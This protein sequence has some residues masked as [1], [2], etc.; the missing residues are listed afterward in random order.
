MFTSLDVHESRPNFRQNLCNDKAF[1]MERS[2]KSTA[3]SRTVLIWGHTG[4]IG[5]KLFAKWPR[6]QW[7]VVAARSRLQDLAAVEAELCATKC[8][9]VVNAAA[10]TGRP[11]VDW[12][13]DHKATVLAVNY[14]APLALAIVCY[15]RNIHCT[16]LG[17]G[18]IYQYDDRH[19]NQ[20]S[21]GDVGFTDKDVPNFRG[22]FYSRTK[23]MLEEAIVAMQLPTLILRFRMPIAG[24]GSERC[25]LTKLRKYKDHVVGGLFNSVSYLPDL[26]PRVP[27]LVGFRTEGVLNFVQPEAVT[28]ETIVKLACPDET[29]HFVPASDLPSLVKAP[30]SNCVLSTVHLQILTTR[31]RQKRVMKAT[32]CLH[33]VAQKQKEQ[34]KLLEK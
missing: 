11:T 14:A 32:D 13:E 7:K 23:A 28:H 8:T 4:W 31:L 6:K 2:E 16:L 25:L 22:S 29:F 10:L 27:D 18:C 20:A 21:D 26:L 34:Q 5:S 12:C 19:P 15:K 1:A 3:P 17:S 24:D 30:R 9:H 33:D